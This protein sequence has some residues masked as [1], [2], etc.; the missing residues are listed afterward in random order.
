MPPQ[1]NIAFQTLKILDDLAP[2]YLI[3]LIEKRCRTR[4]LENSDNILKIPLVKRVRH[5]TNSFCFLAPNI[6]NS[7]SGALRITID[8]EIVSDGL[9]TYFSIYLTA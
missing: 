3:E 1:I 8:L 6:W 7:L 4:I 5:G 9:Q 2:T